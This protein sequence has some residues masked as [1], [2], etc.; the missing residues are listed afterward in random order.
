MG[1]GCRFSSCSFINL[2]SSPKL[3]RLLCYSSKRTIF[4]QQQLQA[5]VEEMR[6]IEYNSGY[7]SSDDGVK[8]D[9]TER[10]SKDE[11]TAQDSDSE[12]Y[13]DNSDVV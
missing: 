9:A 11:S 13:E 7:A 1:L 4:S 8:V 3:N 10:L 5:I 6:G 12:E 2:R